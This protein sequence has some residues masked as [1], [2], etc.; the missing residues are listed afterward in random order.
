MYH[1]LTTK[2]FEDFLSWAVACLETKSRRPM[3]TDDS[4]LCMLMSIKFM[5]LYCNEIISWE[6]FPLCCFPDHALWNDMNRLTLLAYTALSLSRSVLV[7]KV[8]S[9]CNISRCG[10]LIWSLINWVP[11]VGVNPIWVKPN[12]L[13]FSKNIQKWHQILLENPSFF[14]QGRCMLIE[15]QMLE[16]KV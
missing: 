14:L 4:S 16:D 12:P 3:T 1:N 8:I 13:L 15:N 9:V 7:I 2:A 11:G 6:E 5:L 10:D